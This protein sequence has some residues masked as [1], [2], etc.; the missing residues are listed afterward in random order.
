[1]DVFIVSK[2]SA[3]IRSGVAVL[4]VPVA[5]RMLLSIHFWCS[6]MVRRETS[7]SSKILVPTDGRARL[8]GVDLRAMFG[9]VG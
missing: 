6:A 7:R 4:D 5:L 1:M 9:M 2:L 3:D 8:R